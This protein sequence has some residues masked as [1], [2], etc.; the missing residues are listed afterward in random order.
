MEN[1]KPSLLLNC[2]LAYPGVPWERGG[3]ICGL[4]YPAS[5]SRSF[6]SRLKNPAQSIAHD[7]VFS[8]L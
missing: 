3:E 1:T 5:S 6:T 8:R 2:H 7:Q 4:L